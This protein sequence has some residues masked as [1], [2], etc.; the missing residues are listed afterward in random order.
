MLCS[1]P[2]SDYCRT[3]TSTE[4]LLQTVCKVAA[5]DLGVGIVAPFRLFDSSGVACDFIALFPDFGSEQGVLVCHADDWV[6]TNMVAS[7]QGYYCSGLYPDSYGRY[8]RSLWIET[9]NDW[10][11]SGHK[12]DRPAWCKVHN[13]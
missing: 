12:D 3:M 2:S 1:G 10:G 9:F 7:I 11:W 5:T 8:D 13:Q 6:T 4:K